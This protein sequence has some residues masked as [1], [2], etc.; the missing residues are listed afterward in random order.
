MPRSSGEEGYKKHVKDIMETTRQMADGVRLISGLKVMGAA[1]A[2]IVCF[3]STEPAL[4]IYS[5]ADQMSKRSHWALSSHQHPACV[6]LCVTVCH[7]GMVETFLSDLRA[8]VQE[9]RTN[10]DIKKGS[11][12]IYGMTS[13]LPSGPVN[14][15][16]KVYNDVVLRV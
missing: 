16:L 2:M 7:V 1:E 9:V 8:C 10:P 6:H 3:A 5:I 4:N 14:E 13:S 12:A 15:C 11:A